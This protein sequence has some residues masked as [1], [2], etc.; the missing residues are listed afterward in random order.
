MTGWNPHRADRRKGAE[1]MK[2]YEFSADTRAFLESIPIPIAVY[3]Y[4]EEQIKPLL[5][6]RAYLEFFGYRS[7]EEAIFGL[8][9]DL[10]RNV[11]PDDI[12]RME[13]YS[14]CFATQ[15]DHDY[16]IVFRNKREDQTEYHV[17]HGTGKYI[18]VD[19]A[20]L[21]FITYTDES[22]EAGRDQVVK[23]VLTT[24]S[25]KYSPSAGT[26]FAKY[27]DDLT[28]LQNMTHFLDNAMGGIEKIRADG[29]IPAVIYFDLSGLKEY[30]SRYGLKGGRPADPHPV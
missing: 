30:N 5:V 21:A 29:Q 17:V 13:Q 12:S 2:I 1:Y 23:A 28:G 25:G 20:R 7:S 24:L 3:Q 19:G 11:H 14:Y 27:Y 4:V 6:S 10:Y 15:K 8:G 22:A 16:D 9:R 18:T 26:E